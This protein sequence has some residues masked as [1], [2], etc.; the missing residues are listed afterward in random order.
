MEILTR[1]NSP[2]PPQYSSLTC[3][4][5]LLQFFAEA[6]QVSMDV[7]GRAHCSVQEFWKNNPYLAGGAAKAHNAK[8]GTKQPRT[9]DANPVEGVMSNAARKKI[10]KNLTLSGVPQ[11]TVQVIAESLKQ[12]SANTA[13]LALPTGSKTSTG[14]QGGRG[15]GGAGGKKVTK[16]KGGAKGAVAGKGA[17]DN[18]PPCQVT[19][20]TFGWNPGKVG[21]SDRD[22][23]QSCRKQAILNGNSYT[24]KTLGPLMLGSMHQVATKTK[25]AAHAF[26]GQVAPLTQAQLQQAQVQAAQQQQQQQQHALYL[27]QMQQMQ[28]N[29]QAQAQVGNANQAQQVQVAGQ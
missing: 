2:Y 12:V 29:T 7:E 13:N 15:T 6:E 20:C 26:S 16:G 18:R 22:I 4:E 10:T 21:Q 24:H 19:G 17:V 5:V 28:A 23:C 8:A 3:N 9:E 25:P 14:K 27:Q 11:A 1:A